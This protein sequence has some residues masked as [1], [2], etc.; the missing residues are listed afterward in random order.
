MSSVPPVPVSA[1]LGQRP[2]K[3]AQ[4]MFEAKLKRVRAMS[5]V[6]RMKLALKLGEQLQRLSKRPTP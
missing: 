5:A 2:S 1:V 4:A 6:A 3:T